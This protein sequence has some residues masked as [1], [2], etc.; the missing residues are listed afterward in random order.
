M[1]I[2]D[3]EFGP[4]RQCKEGSTEK[5]KNPNP[6]KNSV[7]VPASPFSSTHL[8]S[9]IYLSRYVHS[10]TKVYGKMQ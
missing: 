4:T 9:Y 6:L 2:F 8:L 5:D 10:S 3:T 7:G 1:V